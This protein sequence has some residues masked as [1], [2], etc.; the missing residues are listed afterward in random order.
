MK[1]ISFRLLNYKSFADSGEL[2]FADG[3][4]V[5]V[6]QNNAG[7]S[8]LLQGISLRFDSNP[9]RSLITKP[10]PTSPVSPRSEARISI[11][12]AGGELRDLLLNRGRQFLVALPQGSPGDPRHLQE[13]LDGFFSM[14]RIILNLRKFGGHD[15]EVTKIP[16]LSEYPRHA[17]YWRVQPS[18]DGVAFSHAGSL[19]EHGLGPFTAE[20]GAHI[21]QAFRDQL[22]FFHAERLK[23]AETSFGVSPVLMPDASNLPEVLNVLQAN[24][25]R[26]NRFNRYV[27]QIFPTIRRVAVRPNPGNN[28]LQIVVWTIDPAT[29]REDLAI[30]LADSGTGVGQVLAILYIAVT[31]S[32]ART[33][34][35]DEPNS[36]LNPGAAK[37]L[38]MILRD[39]PNLQFIIATHSPEILQV[40][41]PQTLSVNHWSEGSSTVEQIEPSK[42]ESLQLVLREVGASLSDVFGADRVLW[43]EGPTE[44]ACFRILIET[45]MQRPLMGT[46]IAAVRDTGRLTTRHPSAALVWEIYCKLSGAGALMPAALAFSFDRDG[47]SRREMEDILRQSGGKVH[48]LPRRMYEN[49]LVDAD[50]IAAVLSAEAGEGCVSVE[51]VRSWLESHGNEFLPEGLPNLV[52]SESPWFLEGNGAGLLDR[53]FPD[54]SDNRVFFDKIKHGTRLTKWLIENKPDALQEI[55][56]YLDNILG[57]EPS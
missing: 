27:C 10:T 14:P 24:A 13:I 25:E 19:V 11:E 46:V 56:D 6:G 26:F 38:I 9:H 41:Q 28:A 17:G 29:E 42:M 52:D 31:S 15:F 16:S 30:S 51:M 57:V 49:Y 48:F 43:V 18:S 23:V 36:F 32:T 37:K 7:K 50:A 21:G 20:I 45:L 54:L 3:F 22:Y 33:V 44:E 8:A 1:L 53:M 55:R 34:I 39:F 5:I 47:R 35:I 2:R 40:A 12:C 4:N